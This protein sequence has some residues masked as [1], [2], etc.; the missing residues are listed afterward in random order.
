[1]YMHTYVYMFLCTCMYS[2]YMH[3]LKVLDLTH[4]SQSH[5]Y[6]EIAHASIAKMS[7]RAFICVCVRLHL[8]VLFVINRVRV[9]ARIR[10]YVR[11]Y[12]HDVN[13]I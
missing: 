5:L 1:M 2:T 8:R 7:L 12:M 3:I 9:R 13:F 10:A 4:K 6:A 11:I